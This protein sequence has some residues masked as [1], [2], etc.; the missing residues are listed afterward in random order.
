M[1]ILFH[2]RMLF[3]IIMVK[4]QTIMKMS[5]SCLKILERFV[6]QLIK[7]C[8]SKTEHQNEILGAFH[9]TSSSENLEMVPKISRKTESCR[10]LIRH[11]RLRNSPFTVK[12]SLANVRQPVTIFYSDEE[13]LSKYFP[14]TLHLS[15]ATRML[16]E[17][18]GAVKFLKCEPLNQKFS[19]FREQKEKRK[20]SGRNYRKFWDT[21]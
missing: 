21:T 7:I 6:Q 13:P 3:C 17:N 12:N 10:V 15:L 4:L 19:Q 14:V 8:L 1:I 11:Q 5:W 16:C 9:L 2:F 18:S 20:V